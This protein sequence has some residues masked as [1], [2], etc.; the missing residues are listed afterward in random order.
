[1]EQGREVG[2]VLS[3]VMLPGGVSGPAFAEEARAA[4]PDLSFV[5]MSGY[6]AETAAAKEL[7]PRFEILLSKPFQRTE[8]AAAIQ[9]AL[10]AR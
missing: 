1:M 3:D 5:F 2:V 4:W 10:E 6:P 9:N 8:L 7:L